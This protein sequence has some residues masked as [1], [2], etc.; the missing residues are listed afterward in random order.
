ML[1]QP[2]TTYAKGETVTAT[3]RGAHPKNDLRT[4]DSFLQVQ[5]RTGAGWRTVLTDR[6]WDTTYT[7]ERQGIA[8]SRTSVEWR[9]DERTPPGTYRLVQTGDW[10]NGWTGRVE[11]YR[12][13]SRAFTVR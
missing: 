3:F 5:R 8:A 6:D 12:G 1:T 13:A 2:R 4:E 11:P 7:W 10:K 9:V